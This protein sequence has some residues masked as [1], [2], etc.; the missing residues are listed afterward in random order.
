VQDFFGG[1]SPQILAHRGLALVA[2]ENSLEAFHAALS[3]GASHIE[4]DAH[5]TRD[6]VAVLFHD[7]ALDGRPI[8]D[9]SFDELP[10]YVPSLRQALE[11]F[12]TARFNIDIKSDGAIRAVAHTVTDLAAQG[13]VLITSFSE[14]R[15]SQT[16]S[17]MPGVASSASAQ[18][19]ATALI[20]AKLGLQPLVSW[21]LR[22][23]VAVQIPAR[24]LGMNTVTKR[25][26]AAYHRAGSRVHVWT[27]ND[28]TDMRTHISNGVDGIV[29][30]R[31]D[32]AYAEFF[33]LPDEPDA[34][35]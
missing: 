21:A 35:E 15:R 12:P 6:S 8:S 13:R 17:L 26:I 33:S 7:E 29:T 22:G 20:G 18:R 5:S 2:I 11:A 24:A 14:K 19:F 31:T 10:E 32:L 28:P 23:L 3:A 9:Y 34:T 1:E 27:V 30:D 4:T 25:T 16:V